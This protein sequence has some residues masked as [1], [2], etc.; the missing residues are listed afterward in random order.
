M[1]YAVSG[2]MKIASVLA[3]E[4]ARQTCWSIESPPTTMPYP[5]EKEN[6]LV[7][8]DERNRSCCIS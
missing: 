4:I 7:P 3:E 5:Q 1:H 6:I 2:H 8:K